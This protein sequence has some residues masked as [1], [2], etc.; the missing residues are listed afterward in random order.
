MN[1]YVRYFDREILVHHVDEAIE[2]LA[3]IDEIG[4]NPVLEADIRDYVDSAVF[5][6]KHYKIRPRI[7]FIIIKTEAATMWTLR[8]KRP[9]MPIQSRVGHVIV[10]HR[11]LL[12]S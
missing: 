6:P 3:S 5:Y 1:L 8:R 12:L 9:F 11:L 7:Y 2:F 4:M 10:V